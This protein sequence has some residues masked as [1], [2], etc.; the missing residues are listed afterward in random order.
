[1]VVL[2]VDCGGTW[3]L[4]LVAF[5]VVTLPILMRVQVRVAEGCGGS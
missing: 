5:V 3:N 2:A 1:M 4:V